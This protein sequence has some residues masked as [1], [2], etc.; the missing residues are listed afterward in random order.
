MALMSAW[1]QGVGLRRPSFSSDFFVSFW[2]TDGLTALRLGPWNQ[3]RKALVPVS[4]GN[5][6]PTRCC[7]HQW[8]D[9]IKVFWSPCRRPLLACRRIR[10]NQ[11]IFLDGADP[12]NQGPAPFFGPVEEPLELFAIWLACSQGAA[13]LGVVRSREQAEHATRR[14]PLIHRPGSLKGSEPGDHQENPATVQPER[15]E[16]A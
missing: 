6:V 15:R 9:G 11:S 14:F 1:G 5:R 7:R 8:R 10:Q 16:A 2:K 3:D 13:H 4:Q 12:C